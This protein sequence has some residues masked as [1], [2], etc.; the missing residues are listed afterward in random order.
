MKNLKTQLL[1]NPD[2]RQAYDA[3]APEFELARELIAARTQAGLTQS[4][5]AD[6]LAMQHCGHGEHVTLINYRRPEVEWPQP[7]TT[8]RGRIKWHLMPWTRP[9]L[10][11]EQRRALK[12]LD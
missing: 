6:V 8:L 5:V 4:D 2:V 9:P 11:P 12:Q 3:Q 10:T 1:D 7:P